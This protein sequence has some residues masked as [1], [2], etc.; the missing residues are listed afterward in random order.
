M[1]T[2]FRPLSRRLSAAALLA[3]LALA[4]PAHAQWSSN[5][6]TNLG[7][8]VQPGDQAVPKI[9]ANG[10]G[11]TWMAWFDNRAGSYAVYAQRLDAQGNATFAPGGLLVS[12]NPQSTSLVG[13]DI[14][15]DGAGGCVLVFTDTRSGPDLDVYAYRIDAT[16]SFLWGPNGVTLSNNAD[17]ESNPEVAL[18]S[19]GSFAFTWGRQPTPGPGAIHVQRLDPLGN[20]LFAADGLQIVGA[21]TEKP[22]FSSIV[23][24][25]NGGW[26]VGW[27]RDISTFASPRHLYAQKFDAAGNQLWNGGSPLIVYDFNSLSIGYQFQV[28][29]DEFGGAVFG[30]HRSTTAGNFDVLIQHLD[31]NGVE[32]YAH[33][34]L[35]VCTT[36]ATIELDPAL[37]FIPSTGDT[38][39]VFDKRNTGQ[40]MWSLSV[41]RVQQAG[42][43]PWGGDGI[44]LMP[45]DATQKSILR[46]L[47]FGDGALAFCFWQPSAASQ[48]MDVVGFR[49]DRNGASLWSPA[50]LLV[51]TAPSTKLRVAACVD[52]SG[53]ARLIWGD[54]RNAGGADM[55][56]QNVNCEGTLG[57]TSPC[58]TSSYCVAA[59]NSVGP[60]ALTGSTGSTCVALN[61]LRVTCSGLPPS[62]NGLWFYGANA[63]QIPFG[64]GFRC[65]SGTVFRLGPPQMVSASGT[66]ARFIDLTAPPASSGAGAIT[67][68]STWRFQFW[69]RNVAGGGAGFNLSDGLAAVFCP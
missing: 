17:G 19:D 54:N 29:S 5:P 40:S 56:A 57:N 49:L 63:A 7:I 1:N 33:N 42:Q 12:A 55:Y 14:S 41:Q 66:T 58:G 61:D 53:I 4:V 35:N 37:A 26:I 21:G 45:L 27:V 30:W 50:P 6:A 52:G 62:T 22:G 47:P 24:A 44:D 3:A 68:G 51:S 8:A 64:N 39:V 60:G 18:L 31:Y 46:C 13:W 2:A 69:Y 43:L 48:N 34:G 20:P 9:A 67:A 15:E 16:G 36:A 11:S 10:D 38:Y 32:Y 59:P 25:D 28:L 23:A 65:V